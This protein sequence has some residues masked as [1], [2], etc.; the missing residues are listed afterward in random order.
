VLGARTLVLG[1]RTLELMQS[2]VLIGVGRSV[3]LSSR[4]GS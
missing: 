3:L 1:A 2:P 4:G